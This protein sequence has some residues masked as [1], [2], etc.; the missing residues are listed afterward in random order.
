LARNLLYEIPAEAVRPVSSRMRV[1]IS[2]A[3]DHAVGRPHRF[4]VTSRYASSRESGWMSD[5]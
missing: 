4:S 5:V 1:R 3:V 2:L